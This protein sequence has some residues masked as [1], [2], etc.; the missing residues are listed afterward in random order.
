MCELQDDNPWLE[1]AELEK[2]NVI[3]D[4]A[5]NAIWN[6]ICGEN[7]I[8]SE[9]IKSDKHEDIDGYV[10]RLIDIMNDK[11][12]LVNKITTELDNIMS[13]IMNEADW[14]DE[15]K[16]KVSELDFD[17]LCLINDK[18]TE[19]LKKSRKNLREIVT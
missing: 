3:I 17:M 18:L 9:E 4:E 13:E 6:M 12:E 7:R 14:M 5:L 15:M 8:N 2:I 16:N 19:I 1:L 11:K 10:S